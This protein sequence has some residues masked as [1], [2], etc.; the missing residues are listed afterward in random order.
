MNVVTNYPQTEIK[1]SCAEEK[2]IC[3]LENYTKQF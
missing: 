3:E 2:V 1:V